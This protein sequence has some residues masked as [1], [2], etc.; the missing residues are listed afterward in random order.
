MIRKSAAAIGDLTENKIADRTK[1]VSETSQP[2]NSEG[3]SEHDR[4]IHREWYLYPEQRLKIINDL[5]LI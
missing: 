2:K 1:K 5:R 4:E 3:Q